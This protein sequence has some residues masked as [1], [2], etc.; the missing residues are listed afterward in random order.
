LLGDEI[1][2]AIVATAQVSS[3]NVRNCLREQ[4]AAAAL[5]RRIVKLSTIP[6]TPTGKIRRGELAQQLSLVL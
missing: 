4:F 3:N 6:R 1:I 2:V 5:P